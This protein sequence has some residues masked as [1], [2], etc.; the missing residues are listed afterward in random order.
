MQ[1]SVNPV[2]LTDGEVRDELGQVAQ[3]ITTQEQST[4]AHATIEGA[5]RENPNASTMASKLRDFTKMNPTFYFGSKT[6]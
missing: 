1:V 6:N 4:T 3:E 2:A 5:P